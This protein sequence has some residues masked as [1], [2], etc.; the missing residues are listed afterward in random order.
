LW[1]D[2]S[3]GG[4]GS[5]VCLTATDGPPINGSKITENLLILRVNSDRQPCL[6]MVTC[7]KWKGD[8]EHRLCLNCD[9]DMEKEEKNNKILKVTAVS[10]FKWRYYLFWKSDDGQ[11]DW[12]GDPP[13]PPNRHKNHSLKKRN[14]GGGTCYMLEAEENDDTLEELD[15]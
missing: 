9:T 13:P 2:F 1:K 5:T 15:L 10:V 4:C 12:G 3:L 8:I 14:W 11:S 7:K 6:E